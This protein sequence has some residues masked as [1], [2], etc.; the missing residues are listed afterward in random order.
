MEKI[1]SNNTALSNN[2]IFADISKNMTQKS[3]FKT[4]V[5]FKDYV[6]SNSNE[7]NK[8][9]TKRDFKKSLKSENNEREK[10]ETDDKGFKNNAIKKDSLRK[11]EKINQDSKLKNTSEDKDQIKE[12]DNKVENTSQKDVKLKDNNQNVQGSKEEDEAV[13]ESFETNVYMYNMQ[14]LQNNKMQEEVKEDTVLVSEMSDKNKLQPMTDETPN[15]ESTVLNNLPKDLSPKIESKKTDEIELGGEFSALTGEEDEKTLKTFKEVVKDVSDKNKVQRE[16]SNI[17][18]DTS[19]IDIAREISLLKE[20]IRPVVNNQVN[21]ELNINN[22]VEIESPVNISIDTTGMRSFVSNNKISSTTAGRATLVNEQIQNFA[23]IVDEM[24][25]A[26][27]GNKTSFDIKLEPESLGKLSVRIN[28]E[29]GVFNASFFVDSQKAKQAIENDIHILR[30]SLLEQG[31]NVQEINVQVGQSNQET[32][33][34][35]NIMEA[36]NFSKKGGVRLS[37]DELV[38]EEVINP[39]MVSDEMFNDLY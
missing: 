8:F 23:K 10:T 15:E 35:Q 3:D 30:Q 9:E 27:R 26:F 19:K 37:A 13:E 38:F 21:E 16:N 33:Y 4:D 22:D 17:E 34:H 14:V 39:Y 6:R 2:F 20:D 31:V 29:N 18:N 25:V 12:N 28:S 24:R 7:N 5:S 1:T 11:D 32:N 36:I